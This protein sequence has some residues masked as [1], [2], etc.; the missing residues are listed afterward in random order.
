M[1]L[2][3]HLAHQRIPMVLYMNCLS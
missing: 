3:C 1:H 2:H